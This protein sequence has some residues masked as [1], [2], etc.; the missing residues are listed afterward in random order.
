[1][2]GRY[3]V[4]T[5]NVVEDIRQRIIDPKKYV[6]QSSAQTGSAINLIWFVHSLNLTLKVF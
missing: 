6:P 3:I 5:G 4:L 2:Q 1:M